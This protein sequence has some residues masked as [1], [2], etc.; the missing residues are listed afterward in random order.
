MALEDPKPR[1][2]G[3]APA[4][5]DEWLQ[6]AKSAFESSTNYMDTNLRKG[7]EDNLRHFQ[8]KHHR[9]SKYNT[10]AYKYRS[11]TFRPKTRSSI[12]S[13]EAMAVSAFF[14]NKDVLSIEPQNPLDD[15][16]VASAAINKEI[17]QYRFEN[18]IPWFLLCIGGYQD[19]QKV[20]V[21]VGYVDWK[22]EKRNGTVVKDE[23]FVKLLPPE[24]VRIHPA[25]DWE[26]PVNSSPYLIVLWPMYVKDI[27]RRMKTADEKTGK[28]RWK[29][30]EDGV[31]KSARKQTYDSTRSVREGE[32]TEKYEED[33]DA[34]L[35]FYDIIWCHQNF[36]VDE[37]GR[38]KVFWTLG[39][40]HILTDPVNIE[41]EFHTGERPVVMG[42]CVIETHVAY[43]PGEAELGRPVQLEMNEVSNQRLDNVKFVLNKRWF[44]VRGAQVDT[45]SITR[46][47][48]GSIT[49]VNQQSDVQGQ[50]F[51]DVTASSYHEQDRLNADYDEISGNFSAG[52]IQTNRKLNETVGGMA[53]L[54][55][56][57]SSISEYSIRV[58]AETFVEPVV[59][60]LVKLE[61]CYETDAVILALAGDR[62][63][64]YQRY[65]INH[66]TDQL[67]T[68]NLTTTINVGMG[69]TDPVMKLQNFILGLEALIKAVEAHMKLPGYFDIREIAKEIFGRLGWKDG[70]RFLMGAFTQDPEKMQMMQVIQELQGMIQKLQAQLEDKMEE[71]AT[72]LRITEMKEEGMLQRE[73]IEQKSETARKIMDIRARGGEQKGG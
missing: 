72:K 57:A 13:K 20:G 5:D 61:Q 65:N 18:T 42:Y 23:P 49:F 8:N 24:N 19:A 43:P 55:G 17:I 58:Y 41:D 25:S 44:V 63:Q 39:T 21:V 51:D 15:F 70:E 30:L 50:D 34:P 45:K 67:L 12:R 11:R 64:L 38:E 27:K 37:D 62:A 32:R 7:W 35:G 2:E 16:Q 69:A 4:Q 9:A 14:A 26:D 10:T 68:Q 59:K 46:N 53:M 22:Y 54:R 6:R 48:P 73:L 60:K 71:Q 31:L 66:I 52:S 47:V 40:E 3:E 1:G 56:S 36:M 28:T 33:T 29:K